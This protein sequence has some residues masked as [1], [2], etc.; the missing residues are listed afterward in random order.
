MRKGIKLHAFPDVAR[1]PD[2]LYGQCHMPTPA[3]ATA[4]TPAAEPLD[5]KEL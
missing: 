1:E 3:P 2:G 5:K 4:A